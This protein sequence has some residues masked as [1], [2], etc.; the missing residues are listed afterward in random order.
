MVSTGELRPLAEWDEDYLSTLPVGEFDWLEYKGTEKFTNATWHDDMSKYVSAWANY[1]GG[2]IVF[3]VKDPVS[4]EPLTLDGG[5]PENVRPK[6][7]D[8]LDQVVPRLV[9]PP[10]TRLTTKLIHPKP[11]ESKIKPGNV[12]IAIHIPESEGAPHQARDH[13]YYQRVGR[14]LEPLKDRAIKDIIGRRRFPKLRT[15]ILIHS[16]GFGEPTV[17]WRVENLGSALALHWKAVVKFPTSINNNEITF[18]DED[19]KFC[20]TPDR[21][22]FIELRIPQRLGPPLFPGS[23]TSRSFKLAVVTHRPAL[24]APSIKDI[25]V[26]TFADEMPP[27]TEV[28]QIA[29]AIKTSRRFE[30]PGR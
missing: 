19:V 13:K 1:D 23:D 17:F 11:T 18:P 30:I 10:L 5:I 7:G 20:E 28:I 21:E 14:K 8:W 12:I 22:S 27:F 29:D 3:G 6:L 4:T 9:E 25:R 16:T 24:P 15:T 2:Y 26:T